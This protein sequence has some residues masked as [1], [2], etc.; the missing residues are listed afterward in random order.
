MTETA[1]IPESAPVRSRRRR[2]L[3]RTAIG[4]A[5]LVVAAFGTAWLARKDIADGLIRDALQQYDLPVRYEVRSI[6]PSR[7][8]LANVVI[9]DPAK[10]DMTV[11]RAEVTV[12]YRFGLPAIGTVRLVR[13]RMY[14]RLVDGRVSFGSLDR[15]LYAG[16]SGEPFRLPDLDIGIDDGRALV[17]T[18][19]G[20]VGAKVAGQGRL[21]NGFRGV[22]GVVAPRMTDGDCIATGAS[23]FGTV[24]ITRE[25]PRFTGPLR[26]KDVTCDRTDFAMGPATLGVDA[27]GS[28]R[29]DAVRGRVKVATASI[30]AAGQS[31]GAASGDM[32]VSYGRNGL[33]S[34]VKL[35]GTDVSLAGASLTRLGIDGAVRARDGFDTVSFDGSFSGRGLRPGDGLNRELGSYQDMAEGTL[36]APLLA[37][38]RAALAAEGARSRI[39]GDLK[40]RVGADRTTLTLPSARWLGTSGANLL[41][42]SRV[43]VSLG[44]R[45]GPQVSGNFRTGGRNMPVIVGEAVRGTGGDA[46][47]SL[48]MAD[49]AAGDARLA[50]PRLTVRRNAAGALALDGEVRASGAIP[51]GTVRGLRLPV[52][53]GWAPR[54]GLA[55]WSGCV[56]PVFERLE[57]A[58]LTLQRQSLMVC[59][60][61]G[62]AILRSDARGTRFAGGVPNLA[63]AGTLGETP[64]TIRG[65]PVGLGIPG[66]LVTR[67]LDVSLGAPESATKFRL[68]ELE[69]EIGKDIRGSFAGSEIRLAAVPLDMTR[70]SGRWAWRNEALAI[71]DAALRVTDRQADARFQPMV[72][73][74]ATLTLADNVIT[75]EALLREET[76]DRAIVDVDIRHAL[77]TGTGH[78]D[79]DVP[80]ITFDKRLQPDTVTRLALGTIANAEGTVTGQG[81]IDWNAAGVTSTGAFHTDSLDFAAAFGPVKGLSGTVEFSDLLGLTT[82]PGQRLAIR[83]VNP[84]I[85]VND[86]IV[87]FQLGPDLALNLNSTTFPFMGGTLTMRPTRMILGKAE[88]RNYIFDIVSLDAAQFVQ[89]MELANIQATGTFD[90]TIP[91]IFDENGGRIEGGILISRIPGGN[92]SYIGELTYKDLTPIANFAFD[93]LKSL[94]YT[95]MRILLDGRLEGEIVTRVKI[96]GVKQGAGAKTNFITKRLANLP[97]RFDVNVRAPFMQLLS[98]FK[99]LYD[100]ASV[101]DPRELGLIDGNG[102]AIRGAVSSDEVKPADPG[103]QPAESE[104]MR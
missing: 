44:G 94:D 49:Y 92:V 17:R 29:F 66:K 42:L 9:G 18:D 20:N 71:T 67:N 65:G 48:A 45:G 2:Y 12:R 46:R 22:I 84:G 79:L 11:E 62:G 87:D 43:Q 56:T 26:L 78:A 59:A 41:D 89:R 27:T 7:Q 24:E 90:G 16:P 63:L 5:V 82:R 76:T 91:L 39:D 69:A 37:R 53:G 36:L 3:A 38:M 95:Q 31:L 104:E 98:S 70:A 21:R 60:P 86:G 51:G 15:V 1:D 68:S 32:L 8:V 101:R 40:A 50:I 99:S 19:Y 97:I 4:G 55:L 28:E 35:T 6:G 64:V 25:Q 61:R 54:S 74:G 75:A 10:P 85:V 83:E 80:G 72:A 34:D 81:R 33:A 77:A 96:D 102:N 100:P 52:S 88:V 58:S 14:G 73:R 47:M 103:I 93:A 30:T 13:P 57:L 23:L